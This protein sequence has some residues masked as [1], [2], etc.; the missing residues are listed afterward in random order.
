M[1]NDPISKWPNNTQERENEKYVEIHQ[2]RPMQT[3]SFDSDSLDISSE[4]VEINELYN[5]IE[6]LRNNNE[7]L[8][9][10]NIN[11]KLSIIEEKEKLQKILQIIN[12]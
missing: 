7:R 9:E 10:Y 1:E 5:E 6:N 12:K 4:D 8:R 3:N 2:D 11:L